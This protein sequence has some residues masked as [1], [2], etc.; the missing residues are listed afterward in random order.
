MLFLMLGWQL[1]FLP[2]LG[3]FVDTLSELQFCE[4]NVRC[5]RFLRFVVTAGVTSANSGDCHDLDL[6][7]AEA[8]E[9]LL[10]ATSQISRGMLVFSPRS[11]QP[12]PV[13]AC[14]SMV[15]LS[16]S[17]FVRMKQLGAFFYLL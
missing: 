10:P 16:T 7:A 17:T 8:G 2:C 9:G 3:Q 11:N 13:L 6:G 5:E 15:R 4:L 1:F 12:S 14:A